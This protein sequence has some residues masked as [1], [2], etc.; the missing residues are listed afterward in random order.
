MKIKRF[1]PFT[2]IEVLVSMGLAMGLLIAL[3]GF[4]S[5]VAYLGKLGKEREQQTFETLYL[6]SRLSE[7]LPQAVPLYT[8]AKNKKKDAKSD[9]NFFTTTLNGSPS[10]TFLFSGGASNHPLFSGNCLGRL[11]VN[12]NKQLCFALFPSPSRWNFSGEVPTRIEILSE[13]VER[14]EFAFF[15]PPEANREEMWS[16]LKVPGVKKE[17]EVAHL[18]LSGGQWVFEWRNDYKKLPSLVRL[19]IVKNKEKIK[20]V[21]PVIK[22]EYMIVYE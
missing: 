4:Y 7:L 13:G 14:I 6:Q 12:E 22:S 9:F 8:L 11:Y 15:V 18:P 20:L 21:Y 1:L 19:E 3:M 16:N 10:L 2:L 17:G 5:Y